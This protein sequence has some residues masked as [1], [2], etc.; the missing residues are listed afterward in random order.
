M[1]L[2]GLFGHGNNAVLAAVGYNFRRIIRWLSLL[3][4]QILAALFAR[5]LLNPT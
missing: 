5:L 1:S 2:H 3:L 4:D